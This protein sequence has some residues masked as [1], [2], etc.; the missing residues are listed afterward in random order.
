M[1][2]YESYIEWKNWRTDFSFSEA[3][4]LYFEKE[5]GKIV[6]PGQR[7]VEIGFGAGSFLAWA[8]HRGADVYGVELQE[9]LVT[10]ATKHGFVAVN[11]IDGLLPHR[12]QGFDAVVA[13]DVF[14][15]LSV[16]EITPMLTSIEKL[17]KPAGI[18]TIRVPNGCSPFGL[19]NQYGDATHQTVITPNKLSQLAYSTHLRVVDIRNEARVPNRKAISHRIAKC[20]QFAIRECISKAIAR[21]YGYHGTLDQNMVI[22]LTNTAVH[23]NSD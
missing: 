17:L 2:K 10:A 9:E 11:E 19:G 1:S 20:L 22:V 4:D 13:L 14:E 3:E 15:H 18:L 16:D 23:Q 5:L 6:R 21:V 12:Q 7:I 8:K